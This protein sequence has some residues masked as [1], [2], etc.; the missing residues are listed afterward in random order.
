[1]SVASRYNGNDHNFRP[2]EVPDAAIQCRHQNAADVHVCQPNS[3]L[4]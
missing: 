2:I 3:I 1:M 4:S